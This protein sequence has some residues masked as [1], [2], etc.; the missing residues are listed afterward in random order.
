MELQSNKS[1]SLH[2]GKLTAHVPDD[3]EGFT[4]NTPVVQV[5]SLS[6]PHFEARQTHRHRRLS[7]GRGQRVTKEGERCRPA[8]RS[9]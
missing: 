8:K 1:S 7:V 5:V 4:V 9:N 3:L 2:I 6:H